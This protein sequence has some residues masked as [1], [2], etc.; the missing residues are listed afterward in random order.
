LDVTSAKVEVLTDDGT[1]AIYDL[2]FKLKSG[3]YYS[4]SYAFA[5]TTQNNIMAE[6]N[7]MSSP[8]RYPTACLPSLKRWIPAT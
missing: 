1:Y 5:N 4:G 6:L 7:A 3:T 2:A 8:T